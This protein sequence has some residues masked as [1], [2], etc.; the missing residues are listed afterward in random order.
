MSEGDKDG[1]R[2]EQVNNGAEDLRAN[3]RELRSRPALD[4]EDVRFEGEGVGELRWVEELGEEW[5][6]EG[7]KEGGLGMRWGVEVGDSRI[8]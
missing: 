2:T 5:E 7:R 4:G 6:R 8:R 1:I 3:A